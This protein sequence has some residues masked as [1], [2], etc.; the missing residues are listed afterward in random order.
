[1]DEEIFESEGSEEGQPPPAPLSATAIWGEDEEDPKPRPGIHEL[2][3]EYA[4]PFGYAKP[5][6]YAK[7]ES[8]AETPKRPSTA[9]GAW[10]AGPRKGRIFRRGR[11]G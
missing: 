1:M 5:V 8:A 3:S 2:W 10:A 9:D 11:K 6:E 4:D 7:P